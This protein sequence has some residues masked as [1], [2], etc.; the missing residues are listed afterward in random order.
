MTG[1][2][3]LATAK[4]GSG[5]TCGF[6]LPTIA[7][8]LEANPSP[9]KPNFNRNTKAL[10]AIVVI[11][12]TRE[13]ALQIHEQ[14]RPFAAAGGVRTACVYGGAPKGPQIRDLQNAAQL[15]IATP[16]RL[17]DLLNFKCS[18]G[19]AP[20]A[21]DQVK[22]LVLDEADRMCDMGFEEDIKKI[23]ATMPTSKQTLFFTATWPKAVARVAA[24]ILQKPIQVSIGAHDELRANKDIKQVVQVTDQ[25]SKHDLLMELVS[26]E[27]TEGTR[28]LVFCNK[29]YICD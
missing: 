28:T 13:L 23:T 5:K 29:K 10:P 4:T 27:V 2:D 18:N 21:M 9:I 8:Y 25:G 17:N 16:G 6:L 20:L 14:A 11:A 1:R 7:R 12:P 3:L 26:K 22:M 24:T 15:V 19:S